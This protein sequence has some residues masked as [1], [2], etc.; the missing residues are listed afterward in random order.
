MARR[1]KS[2]PTPHLHSTCVIISW[3]LRVKRAS[4]E[5]GVVARLTG[6]DIII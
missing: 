3:M 6:V 4:S 1:K 5:L 2:F